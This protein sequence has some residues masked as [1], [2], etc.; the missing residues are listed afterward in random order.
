[1]YPE[2]GFGESS[3]PLH[4]P[5]PSVPLGGKVKSRLTTTPQDDVP[6]SV[7]VPLTKN[8]QQRS[9]VGEVLASDRHPSIG[10]KLFVSSTENEPPRYGTGGIVVRLGDKYYQKT[11]GHID[12]SECGPIPQQSPDDIDYCRFD[13]DSDEEDNYML[14]LDSDITSRGSMTPED[15]LSRADSFDDSDTAS[16]GLTAS[17]SSPGDPWL[18]PQSENIDAIDV[19]HQSSPSDDDME[20][21]PGLTNVGKLEHNSRSGKNPG[22]DYAF[23]R[24]N[25]TFDPEKANRICVDPIANTHVQIRGVEP[26]AAV[27]RD[28]VTVTA[29]GGPARGKIMPSA[30]YFR[31]PSQK[32]LQKLYVVHLSTVV[33]DGDC[34]ADVV[35]A[36]TGSLY[37]HIVRGCRGEQ[38]A[39]IVS[40]KEVFEDLEDRLGVSPEIVLLGQT[41]DFTK[42][43]TEN[44]Y[45]GSSP[46]VPSQQQSYIHPDDD[47]SNDLDF[48]LYFDLIDPSDSRYQSPP[49]LLMQ[50]TTSDCHADSFEYC[51]MP[52]HT[53]EPTSLDPARQTI[54]L[55]SWPGYSSYPSLLPSYPV[56]KSDG[57]SK[58]P[59]DDR[60]SATRLQPPD[61][62]PGYEMSPPASHNS[63]PHAARR[64]RLAL[65]GEP[66]RPERWS[67]A[68]TP[69][70]TA[71]N[72]VFDFASQEILFPVQTAD[73]AQNSVD[74]DPIGG[75][76]HVLSQ[77]RD[78]THSDEEC[79]AEIDNVISIK[80]LG[81]RYLVLEGT[82][83]AIHHGTIKQADIP[84]Y[85]A[86]SH[87]W[88]EP[89]SS[90][91]TRVINGHRF[92]GLAGFVD[93]LQ[94]Q[95]RRSPSL[96]CC[97]DTIALTPDKDI[98][99]I[100]SEFVGY[101]SCNEQISLDDTEEWIEHIMT[102][103]LRDEP[104][105]KSGCWYCDDPI[106][107]V[108]RS[109]LHPMINFRNRL[110]H[111]WGHIRNDNSSEGQTR[112]DFIWAP[113]TRRMRADPSCPSEGITITLGRKNH[114]KLLSVLSGLETIW[115]HHLWVLQEKDVA[116]TLSRAS[117]VLRRT[118]TRYSLGL[119]H[120]QPWQERY[121]P[122]MLDMI[123]NASP[124]TLQDARF[125]AANHPA[126]SELDVWAMRS[127]FS[128]TIE[129]V[130]S[131]NHFFDKPQER[132]LL[133][134]SD[135]YYARGKQTD[136]KRDLLSLS[137]RAPDEAT[138]PIWVPI[139]TTMDMSNIIVS[140]FPGTGDA[141]SHPETVEL[142][143]GIL[144]AHVA[145]SVGQRRIPR[146]NHMCLVPECESETLQRISDLQRHHKQ[147]KQPED[148]AKQSNCDHTRC[149]RN[150][151]PSH[152]MDHFRDHYHDFPKE[153]QSALLLNPELR[154][155][156]DDENALMAMI[157]HSCLNLLNCPGCVSPRFRWWWP[158]GW[159]DPD[160]V[161]DEITAIVGSGFG[162]GEIGDVEDSV[163]ADL[164]PAVYGWGQER[165]NTAV[166][167]AYEKGNEYVRENLQS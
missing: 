31:S 8:P 145:K 13:D 18:Y 71:S 6:S 129:S 36:K 15:N 90:S 119:H 112:S 76:A 148:H 59:G 85:A 98:H 157:W 149:K 121:F 40:A 62:S 165:W 111:I 102:Q 48:D 118:G 5:M 34:G 164:D 70:P 158:G 116:S 146:G 57:K 79:D 46:Y 123:R 51:S 63:R 97:V 135:S 56:A 66:E 133:W 75:S 55:E 65:K 156:M 43:R 125:D 136:R 82:R 161:V 139:W 159:I 101:T 89:D 94:T 73:F 109:D 12:E 104:L 134:T 163:K 1:M 131:S 69:S 130:L 21:L 10:R 30:V 22:L 87:T 35:D 27:V 144:Q 99:I 28:I 166:L 92:H 60:I 152:Q 24:L 95:R 19:A 38:I 77:E 2:F 143:Q 37:G 9:R 80:P 151:E 53:L 29:S 32:S 3:V 17:A 45:K 33:V 132:L 115:Q 20:E 81:R 154:R 122:S 83:T 160:E 93:L 16:L 100:P 140:N 61:P 39:Y 107:E 41:G 108:Q 74:N 64:R 68:A 25:D 147:I 128:K 86:L 23:V 103:H 117:E 11:V 153:N 72:S 42:H 137:T 54:G 84:E 110:G 14:Q 141:S 44:H 106:S 150:A 124:Q 47:P 96:S 49:A 113:L 91:A 105:E 162:G 120:P 138:L 58:F 50:H 52:Q 142:V 67:R 7:H 78:D 167:K 4:E 127:I 88:L 126:K 114:F 26:I 155:L